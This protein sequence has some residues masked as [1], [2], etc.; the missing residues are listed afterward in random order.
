MMED[1]R[2]AVQYLGRIFERDHFYNCFSVCLCMCLSTCVC[3]SVCCCRD[4][5]VSNLLM[6]DVGCVKIGNSF[7]TCPVIKHYYLS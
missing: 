1:K 2:R 3:L 6:T 4:L 5:K 7:T